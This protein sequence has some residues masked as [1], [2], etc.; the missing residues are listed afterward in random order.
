MTV[1]E[2]IKKLA[3]PLAV[4]VALSTS[5]G[6]AMADPTKKFSLGT[7]GEIVANGDSDIH[8][9]ELNGQYTVN[10]NDGGV[11]FSVDKST[12][13]TM[14][15]GG[16]AVNLEDFAVNADGKI[17]GMIAA[18]ETGVYSGS[19]A[20][21]EGM[22]SVT[23]GGDNS[24]LPLIIFVTAGGII[25]ASSSGSSSGGGTPP[26]P[27]DDMTPAPPAPA[28]AGGGGGGGGAPAPA[29]PTP[30]VT[31]PTPPPTTPTPPPTMSPS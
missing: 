27:A 8:V 2:Q 19:V 30:V 5:A 12:P 6:T 20:T 29:A 22:V 15:A 25:G 1:A 17:T 3:V 26:A 13:L 31:A 10:L 23:E 4:G 14:T 7:S 9:D 16:S 21:C 28:P 24:A 18:G 11:C